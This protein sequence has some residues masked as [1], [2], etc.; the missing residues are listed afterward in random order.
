MENAEK[1]DA[2]K[3]CLLHDFAAGL[4]LS[5]SAENFSWLDFGDVNLRNFY[6]VSSLALILK[7]AGPACLQKI[8]AVFVHTSAYDPAF[9]W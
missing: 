4:K 9:T 2:G 3:P 1:A 8:L 6:L 5:G 7:I